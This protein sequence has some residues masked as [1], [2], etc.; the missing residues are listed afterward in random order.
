MDR[1][2]TLVHRSR[3]RAIERLAGGRGASSTSGAAPGCSSTRSLP[4]LA[5][6]AGTSARH[7]P[8]TGTRTSSIS[9]WPRWTSTTGSR[10][11]ATTYDAVVRSGEPSPCARETIRGIWPGCCARSVLPHRRA[12]FGSQRRPVGWDGPGGSLDVPRHLVHFTPRPTPP[13]AD[14][15]RTP[16][17]VLRRS[18]T[19]PRVHLFSFVQTVENRL[20]LPPNLLYDVLRRP[21]SEAGGADRAVRL[22]Q[23]GLAVGFAVPLTMPRGRAHHLQPRR[24]RQRHHCRLCGADFRSSRSMRR[25]RSPRR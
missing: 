15:G 2:L 5:G 21:E 16:G 3:I 13:R 19:C 6:S 10:R 1:V 17:S 14:P 20:G 18:A 7:P 25:E 22:P 8:R 9:T 24:G 4:R 11:R 23:A 12:H